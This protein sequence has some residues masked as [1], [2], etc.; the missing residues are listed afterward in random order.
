[1]VDA[2]RASLGV[3]SDS[4][5]FYWDEFGS[6]NVWERNVVDTKIDPRDERNQD[7][8]TSP[9]GMTW[10]GSRSTPGSRDKPPKFNSGAIPQICL[11]MRMRLDCRVI[12]KEG[13][14][15]ARF[16]VL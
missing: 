3:V 11:S 12:N 5:D 15:R 10:S 16:N 8:S 1:M 2:I 7:F 4:D 14:V 9:N 13:V 6:G